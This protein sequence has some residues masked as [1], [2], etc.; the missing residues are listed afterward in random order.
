MFYN[1]T[2]T[3]VAISQPKVAKNSRNLAGIEAWKQKIPE[4]LHKVPSINTH[5]HTHC[6]PFGRHMRV[7]VYKYAIVSRNEQ[8]KQQQSCR[9]N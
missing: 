3:S 1:S 4:K 8:E 7:Y 5:T 6:A 2:L 9:L